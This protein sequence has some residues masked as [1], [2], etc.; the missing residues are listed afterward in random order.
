MIGS[1]RIDCR[2]AAWSICCRASR[3]A[4]RRRRAS[5]RRRC[6]VGL[7][8]S[9]TVPLGV[10]ERRIC[11]QAQ[12][13]SQTRG[14]APEPPAAVA[15]P[16]ADGGE[17]A[18]RSPGCP[19]WRPVLAVQASTGNGRTVGRPADV[20]SPFEAGGR[21]VYKRSEPLGDVFMPDSYVLLKVCDEG[22]NLSVQRKY[23]INFV[24]VGFQSALSPYL[25]LFGLE[26]RHI[27]RS[28]Y[29]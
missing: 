27:L 25:F 14:H 9:A 2:S 28:D 29:G 15:A 20:H 12:G 8:L 13:R 5:A 1:A 22:V 7:A 19:R 18:V 26:G 21:S 11:P 10:I 3:T 16:R 23:E 6:S 17:T 4:W 24:L